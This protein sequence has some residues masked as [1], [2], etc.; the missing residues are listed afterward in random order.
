MWSYVVT[1]AFVELVA[2]IST[3]T[4][5][6]VQ[7]DVNARP[8]LVGGYFGMLLKACIFCPEVVIA[9][10]A[11]GDVLMLSIACLSSRDPVIC[12]Q[13]FACLLKLLQS[14]VGDARLM[15]TFEPCL[16]RFVGAVLYAIADTAPAHQLGKLADILQVRDYPLLGKNSVSYL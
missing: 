2:G 11:M 14:S 5:T 9:S 7:T 3:V 16:G 8:L 1:S 12:G 4:F 6:L 13:L 10:P 15:A